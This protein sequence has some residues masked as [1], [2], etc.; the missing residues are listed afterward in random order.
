MACDELMSAPHGCQAEMT[1]LLAAARAIVPLAVCQT[2]NN[3]KA[4]SVCSPS[5]LGR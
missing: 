2:C 4:I 3:L 1:G 5:V